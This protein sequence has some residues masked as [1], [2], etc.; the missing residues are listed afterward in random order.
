MKRTYEDREWFNYKAFE[1]R[2]KKP[3]TVKFVKDGG[4][5][6][7]HLKISGQI[8]IEALEEIFEDQ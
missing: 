4:H 8:D 5:R 1:K 3:K 7:N 2:E 6:K